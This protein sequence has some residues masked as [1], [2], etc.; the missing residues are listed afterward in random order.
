MFGLESVF[1]FMDLFSAHLKVAGMYEKNNFYIFYVPRDMT[2]LL[3]ML[4]VSI[5]RSFQQFMAA[6]LMNMCKNQLK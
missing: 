6:V 2:P 1:I 5:N 3:Q 4:G